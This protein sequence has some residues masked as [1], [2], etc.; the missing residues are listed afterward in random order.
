M[1]TLRRL[2][3]FWNQYWFTPRPLFD[4]AVVRVFAVGFGMFLLISGWPVGGEFAR[5][6]GNTDL[7]RPLSMVRLCTLSYGQNWMPPLSTLHAVFYVTLAAGFLGVIGLFTKPS[8]VVFA[9]GSI[10]MQ[11]F[12]YS[13]GHFH[14][15]DAIL[16]FAFIVLALSPC[17]HVLS[18]DAMIR[19]R[20]EF[21]DLDAKSPFAG[22][23]LLFI[24]WMF[25]LIYASAAYSKLRHG[26]E[27]M[28]GYS[29]QFY[30]AQ[31]ALRWD[32]P[33]G[34]WLAGHHGLSIVLS[35]FTVGFEATFFL[36]MLFPKLRWAY[37]SIGI[38]FHFGIYYLMAAPFF[39]FMTL[40]SVF[41]PWSEFFEWIRERAAGLQPGQAFEE[42]LLRS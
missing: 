30:L 16:M 32:R 31:D 9:A 13:F 4:L 20:N 10:F 33:A 24:Q 42:P 5:L 3:V 34:L 40:Y 23:P 28:N 27:W 14:H 22:W 11:A 19:R 8:L 18:V 1:N 12:R 36:V 37:L 2:V 29:L 15:P 35:W 7:F 25:V 41:V 39:T 21:F 26:F 17:G 38:A 6:Q